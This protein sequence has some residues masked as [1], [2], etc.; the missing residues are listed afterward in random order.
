MAHSAN[1]GRGRRCR[2]LG[3]VIEHLYSA[4]QR[5]RAQEASGVESFPNGVND[6]SI[7]F[8]RFS[9]NHVAYPDNLICFSVSHVNFFTWRGGPKSIAKLDG[10]GLWPDLPSGSANEWS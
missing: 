9:H 6:G 2:Y 4:T 8:Y 5:A 10:V 7:H 3:I 1:R